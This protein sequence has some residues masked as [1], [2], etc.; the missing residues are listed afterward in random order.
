MSFVTD[1][2]D[3]TEKD[4]AR[5]GGKFYALARL[6]QSGLNVP[7]AICIRTSAYQAF[8]QSTG[9]S[10]RIRLE[11]SRK[12][13]EDMRWEE[14]WDSALRI[15]NL[16]ANTSLP[17]DLAKPIRRAI[18]GYFNEKKVVV[19]SSAPAEDSAQASFAGLHE[20]YVNVHGVDAVVEHVQKVWA[21]LWSDAALLYRREL[22]L[23]I[24]TSSMAVIIQEIVSGE[25]SGVVFGQSPQDASQAVIESVYGLN[26]GLVDGTVEPDN[27]VLERSTGN[28][29][30]HTAPKRTTTFVPSAEGV[31]LV[32]LDPA[33]SERPPLDE[34]KVAEVYGLAMRAE[35][36]FGDPQD[37]EWTILGEDL[38][39]LQSRPITTLKDDQGDDRRPWYLSL[40]R[41]LENLKTLRDRI[42]NDLIPEMITEGSRLAQED[43]SALS[44]RQ[45]ADE[46]E[47]RKD[48]YDHWLKVY[49]RD[50]IPFAHGM[51]LFGQVYND[52]MRPSDPYEFMDL[53][54]TAKMLSLER[55]R[56]LGELASIIAKDPQL[57]EELRTQPKKTSNREFSKKL[58]EFLKTFGDLSW[59]QSRNLGDQ[60]TLI[61]VLLQMAEHPPAKETP[62]RRDPTAL[63]DE[64]FV[65]FGE[66]RRDK[67]MELLDLGRASYRLRDD[68][69]IHL[70][71]IE[72][73]MLLALKEG[74]R[75]IEKQPTPG[76]ESDRLRGIVEAFEKPKAVEAPDD[77]RSEAG[78][79]AKPRQL[80]GQPAGPGL[81]QG[82]ARVIAS[83]S[84]LANFKAGEI[85]VCDAIDPNMTFLVPLS[86]GIVERRGGM[87]IHGAIIAREYGLP[88]VTGIP[89][90]TDL[91]HT[92]DLITVDGYLGIVIIG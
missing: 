37:V 58:G 27:W 23:D 29:V 31:K 45:L 7:R 89:N 20:S 59:E 41:S 74:K 42:E 64:F 85:L 75:R 13:F 65:R 51:R 46:I 55:N 53:L 68:D 70:G 79:T 61:P 24:E 72:G 69:N 67:A 47:R 1:L 32:A 52:V 15:R 49:W 48:V 6:L 14:I 4:R 60:N 33:K 35:D 3:I 88:C 86:K 56:K 38:F 50:F 81:S 54:G 34:K 92:G 11:M 87:L 18:V 39:T 80:L 36:V 71:K 12:R 62:R 40:R 25:C 2:K 76:P 22:A 26:Q 30:S 10:E 91:I 43:P 66:G 73:Q 84:D 77:T 28:V 8:I 78:Y 83:S 17:P 82:P 19:R 5:V 16:F 90:A 21:S 63:R 44:D 9:L 57:A